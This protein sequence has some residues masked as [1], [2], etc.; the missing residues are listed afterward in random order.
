MSDNVKDKIEGFQ[1]KH[2]REK[3][4]ASFIDVAR[5]PCGRIK[6]AS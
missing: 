2:N 5:G 1:T 3:A 6:L 4:A